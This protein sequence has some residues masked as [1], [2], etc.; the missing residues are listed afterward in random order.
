MRYIF[1]LS[2]A[3]LMTTALSCTPALPPSDG[4]GSTVSHSRVVLD[5]TEGSI[6][7]E[8]FDEAAPQVVEQFL[9]NVA[10]GYYDSSVV[11][12]IANRGYFQAGRFD[13]SLNPLPSQP[14]N[15]ESDNGL[16][17]LRGRVAVYGPADGGSGV[18]YLLFNVADNASFNAPTGGTS[19]Y[20]VIGRV[21]D[22]LSVADAIAGKTTTTKT[23]TD[24]TNL[25][26]APQ[27]NIIINRI[28][29]I[30]STGNQ[31]PVADAG[32]NQTASV[33]Q[34]VT[35]DASA[36]SDPDGDTLSYVWSQTSGPA[37]NLENP[38]SVQATFTP[39]EVATLGFQVIVADGRGGSSTAAV[40]VSVRSESNQPP[41]ASA[42]ADQSVLAGTSVTLSAAGSSDPDA[43]D[44]LSYEWTQLSGPSVTLNDANAQQATFTAPASTGTLVF[45]LTVTDSAGG[46]AT[47]TVQISVSVNSPPVASAGEDENV[48][49][50]NV[51][52]LDASG[53]FDP[54]A[55]DTLTY[56]WQQTEG[57]PV[58]LN[59]PTAVQQR[60]TV[61][62]GADRF[63]FDVV[64]TDS[65]GATAVDSVTYTVVTGPLVRMRTTLG[66][67]VIE[68]FE[69][70]APATTENFLQ[71]VD[72]GFYN[73]TIIH[74]VLS[75]FVVQGGGYL[76]DLTEQ[77][78]LRAPVVN[79]FSPRRSN[80]R[81]TVAMAKRGNDPNSATS[82]FFVNVAD[83][84][85]NLDNQ[86]GGF[87]VFGRV[88][89][90]MDVIDRIAQVPTADRA[91]PSSQNF[92]DV[93]IDT[94]EVTNAARQ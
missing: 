90:G 5:T 68:L 83:N 53:S 70:Q 46:R 3:V 26:R 54:D 48:H 66:D 91:D 39:A 32:Q 41:V 73:G 87:T 74:R 75:D 58:V 19:N 4:T 64:V 20:T 31:S 34:Q 14:L 78:P 71:Y 80:I 89:Q 44:T 59:D 47:D 49:V 28:T 10:A 15:N 94:I 51:I 40:T 33:G 77:T 63:S 11:H 84:A 2:L 85:S 92:Q 42:G 82:Q 7:V 18:P 27:Q 24:G 67:F 25:P 30:S 60:F 50:T 35:L 23:A 93:P 72:S 88:S 76:P 86:N 65:R 9:A 36:S 69:D 29:S 12:D 43:G 79:E 81:T 62:E 45:Q 57:S 38:N 37:V 21:S 52:T 17:N 56:Q 1:G 6:T 61:S 8:L 55:G 13:S 22:G 16:A